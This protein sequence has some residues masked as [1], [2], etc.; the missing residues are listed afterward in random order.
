MKNSILFS[1]LFCSLMLIAQDSDEEKLI[2]DKGTW[3]IGGNLS[4]TFSENE[5]VF[6]EQQSS[7][8][9]KNFNITIQPNIGYAIGKNL[10]LGSSIG[11]GFGSGDSSSRTGGL[12]DNLSSA[13]SES[14]SWNIA[15][16]VRAFLPI[17][18][19][20]AFYVQGEVGYSASKSSSSSEQN[21]FIN[22]NESRN[23]GYS[24]GLRPGLTYFITNHLALE[25][26]LGFLGYST[27][28]FE[29]KDENDTVSRTSE[30]GNFGFNFNNS[31]L[32]FGLSCYF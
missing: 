29:S 8:N 14:T 5:N 4:L 32:L 10:M 13:E 2:I 28:T 12:P 3:N 7:N 9:L 21:S 25:T 22:T 15:P 11:L 6:N 16:Y 24:A 23:T 18:K 17:G 31:Q 19:R 1:V 27:N 20:A 26:Q 30:N